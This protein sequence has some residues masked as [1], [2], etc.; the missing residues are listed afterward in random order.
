MIKYILQQVVD[1]I[2][3]SIYWRNE[4]MSLKDQQA[5][6]AKVVE[7]LKS[8]VVN[9]TGE[10]ALINDKVV[11][12]EAQIAALETRIAEFD[13]I[14][15]SNEIAVIKASVDEIKAISDAKPAPAVDEVP[16]ALATPGVVLA[17]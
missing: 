7:D 13:G 2:Y 17:D 3:V 15:L 10:V 4:I 12:L 16:A 11:K 1:F 5:E 14:D 9:E 8:T 6:L